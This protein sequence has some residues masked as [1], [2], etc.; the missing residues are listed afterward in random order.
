MQNI[1]LAHILFICCI[2]SFTHA[3]NYALDFDGVDDY[4]YTSS[5]VVLNNFTIEMW[6]MADSTHEIDSENTGGWPG[7]SG[8]RWLF[9]PNH[10][11]DFDGGCGISMGT[12]GVSVYEHGSSYLP[13]LLVY[14]TPLG[15]NWHHIAV[16][17]LNKQPHLFIDG[18]LVRTGLQSLRSNVLSPTIMGGYFYGFFDGSIDEVRIWDHARTQ[19]QI[20]NKMN[21]V[22]TGYEDGLWGYWRIDE[23]QGQNVQDLSANDNDAQLGDSTVFDISDPV[24]IIS[25]TPLNY[26]LAVLSHNPSGYNTNAV[27]HVE[28]EFSKS[29]NSASFELDDISI[30]GPDHSINPNSIQYLG[31]NKWQINFNLQ[32]SYGDYHV[33]VGPHIEDPNDA[34]MDQNNNGIQGE[35]P[36]D[37]YDAAFTIT[38][39]IYFTSDTTIDEGDVTY[40]GKSIIIDNCMLTINGTHTFQNIHILPH[41]ILT[42]GIGVDTFALTI[43]GNLTIDLN[44][45]IDVSGKGHSGSAGP[46]AGIGCRPGIPLIG[47]GGTYGGVGGNVCGNE[48]AVYGSITEPVDL[49]S[50][51]GRYL[52]GGMSGGGLLRLNVAG[53]LYI[54]GSI[55]ANGANNYDTFHCHGGGSGGSIHIA[56][57]AIEGSGAITANGGDAG[58]YCGGGGGGRI[59]IFCYSNFF[60]GMITV[61]G[62]TG[63]ES[64]EAGTIFIDKLFYSIDC[65]MADPNETYLS[66]GDF[67][68][69]GIVGQP[70]DRVLRGGDFTLTGGF[71][72]TLQELQ[73]PCSDGQDNDGDGFVDFPEDI[74]CVSAIDISE[75]D[76][77][78]NGDGMVNI[79]DLAKLSVKWLHYDPYIDV[80]PYPHGDNTVNLLEYQLLSENWGP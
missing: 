71:L 12:N 3:Q 5:Q 43:V 66:G 36:D 72:T 78:Y 67:E 61:D 30:E 50:G 28:L 32:N 35:D 74:G 11:G 25:E 58:T 13:A 17:Y 76:G 41:G 49:G 80:L 77:D 26:G 40:N 31:D 69:K 56:A 60:D 10:G 52:G 57:N 59:A 20:A 21:Y 37:I 45:M 18:A 23:G 65:G 70:E 79:E 24:W 33:Y 55:N 15:N 46:G 27:D 14:E 9:Y 1:L 19:Q 39:A 6:A 75:R 38:D 51:G 7:I 47:N 64:G 48:K 68:L 62:G 16:V 2:F 73:T 4:L 34:E 54:D 53:R 63:L 29:V 44:G 8:Q 22:L 42:H